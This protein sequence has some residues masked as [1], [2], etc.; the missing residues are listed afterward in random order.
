[1]LIALSR[2]RSLLVA[3]ALVVAVAGLAAPTVAGSHGD[4]MQAADHHCSQA[5][6]SIGGLPRPDLFGWAEAAEPTVFASPVVLA[7]LK[8]PLGA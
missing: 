3:V 8:I 5:L 6:P 1:M 4:C 7:I 2:R